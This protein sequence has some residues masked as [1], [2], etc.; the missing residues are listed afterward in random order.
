MASSLGGMIRTRNFSGRNVCGTLGFLLVLGCGKGEAADP[1]DL[2]GDYPGQTDEAEP[3]PGE[4]VDRVA[5]L[6]ECRVAAKRLEQIALELVVKEEGDPEERAKLEE[7]KKAELASPEFASRVEE[8]ARDCIARET[9]QREA[10]C[11]ARAINDIGLE[12]CEKH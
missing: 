12:R 2:I 10:A 11:I 8:G 6:Q 9:T 7:R 1:H 4:P 3:K 5:T